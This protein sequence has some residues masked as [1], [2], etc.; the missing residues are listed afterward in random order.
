MTNLNLAAANLVSS[1]MLGRSGSMQTD[2]FSHV[3]AECARY[4]VP[5]DALAL[6]RDMHAIL[7]F[8]KP[9]GANQMAAM[10][11]PLVAWRT[12]PTQPTFERVVDVERLAFH[13]RILIA[14]GGGETD[15]MVGRAE[16]VHAMGNLIK[17]V[18]GDSVPE[19]Y[20]EV[21]QWAATDTL[22][23]IQG[24][25][26][27]EVLKEKAERGWKR[28]PDAEVLLPDGRLF[29]TYQEICTNL[30]R[31]A[32]AFMDKHPLQHPRIVLRPW[33]ATYV[34]DLNKVREELVR[35][36]KTDLVDHLD[37]Q[38]ATIARMFPDLGKVDD[39]I[40]THY[41]DVAREL[42]A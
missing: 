3:L 30:R 23:R 11:A 17:D 33:A 1:T 40:D 34:R 31:E 18:P 27:E 2:F 41:R 26:K 36:S 37:Q 8:S 32:L 35:E 28:I 5:R 13:Q 6:F 14:L 7:G 38:L 39:E 22:A 12:H 4:G 25:S 20:Y 19:E 15:E 9:I 42:T 29:K 10:T 21:F 16:I 24:V